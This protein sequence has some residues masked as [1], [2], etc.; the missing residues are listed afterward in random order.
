MKVTNLKT[1][2][3]RDAFGIDETPYFSWWLESNQENVMQEAYRIC[4]ADENGS[5]IWDSGK[6]ESSQNTFVPYEGCSLESRGIY[7]WT[8]TV[9]DNHGRAA[10]GSQSFEMALLHSEDWKA[11]WVQSPM[12]RK[13]TKKGVGKVICI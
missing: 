1:C 4:V 3:M 13:K 7:T 5:T 2:H 8:V 10:S 12:K 9:W 6:V 11:K